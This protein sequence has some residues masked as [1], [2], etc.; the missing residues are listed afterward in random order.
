LNQRSVI[1]PD[2]L[3]AAYAAGYFPMAE[4]R[5]GPIGWLSPDPRAIIPLDGFRVSR[6]LRQTLKK[7][8]FEV[9]IDTA[10]EQVMRFCAEREETWISE[11]IIASYAGLH[12]F[13]HAHSVEAWREGTLVGGLYGVAIGGAF[14]GESMFSRAREGSKVALAWLV[15]RMRE[16]RFELLDTQFLT[17]HLAS[18]GAIEISREEYLRL[19]TRA[20][21]LRCRFD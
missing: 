19:L 2:F 20:L 8:S 17:P 4:S 14:F 10:F 16:R 11:E 15:E 18:L 9:R 7:R 6:S 21:Q 5:E 3:L 13:G 12:H 1:E